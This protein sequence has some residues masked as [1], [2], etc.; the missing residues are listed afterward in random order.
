[1]RSIGLAGIIAVSSA[2]TALAQQV[3]EPFNGRVLATRVC[4]ECHAIE[5]GAAAAKSPNENAPAFAAVANTAGINE[6]ALTVFLRSFHPTMPNLI[7][8]DAQTRDVI[9]YILSLTR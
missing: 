3:G 9:A 7:L 5:A 2:A 6:L 4:A 8:S 1:V